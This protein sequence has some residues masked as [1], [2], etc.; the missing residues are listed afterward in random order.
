MAVVTEY[1]LIP[2]EGP[3][4]IP[5][6]LL[7]TV[8][9]IR[10]PD[11]YYSGTPSL[12][13]EVPQKVLLFSRH[14][15]NRPSFRDSVHH[16]FLLVLNLSGKGSAVI[17]SVRFFLPV[18][19]AVLIFPHQYHH[20]FPEQDEF[21]WLFVT[22]EMAEYTE[23]N[24]L[25]NT[26]T[27]FTPETVPHLEQLTACWRDRDPESRRDILRIVYLTGLVLN[28]L[29]LSRPM[30]E[31]GG[32][33]KNTAW[34]DGI[35]QYIGKNISRPLCVAEIAEYAALSPSRFRALYREKMGISAGRYVR[36]FKLRKAQ[37][38]LTAT[39]M[40]ISEISLACGYRTP[41]AFSH[42]FKNYTGV[43]PTEYRK[44]H[45]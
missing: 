20:F 29:S 35:N 38:L 42:A 7:D 1:L 16:R 19:S 33:G 18:Q 21:H 30:P 10:D 36:E 23:F 24:P 27:V 12:L 43:S 4:L 45:A 3:I 28:S 25:K 39:D 13:P 44:G 22:F 2:T 14:L 5:L 11:D 40:R 26:V 17:D 37:G 31:P 6:R 34:I 32:A 15:K 41:Y 8:S 9:R